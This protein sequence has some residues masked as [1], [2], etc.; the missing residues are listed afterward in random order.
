MKSFRQLYDKYVLIPKQFYESSSLK[1]RNTVKIIFIISII[2]GSLVLPIAFIENHFF[3][4]QIRPH[5]YTYYSFFLIVGVLGL[6]LRKTKI[7]TSALILLVLVLSQYVI[8]V[9]FVNAPFSSSVIIFIGFQFAFIMA[10][11]MN[12]V[13][14][15]A[16]LL[17]YTIFISVLEKNGIL[18]LNLPV[19][20]SFLINSSLFILV[21]FFLAFWKRKYQ[22]DEYIRDEKLS[23]ETKKSDELLHNILPDSVIEQLKTEGKVPPKNYENITVLVSDIV[24]F[25]K[26]ATDLP[27]YVLLIELN[28]IFT[29]FDRI[30]ETHNCIRIKTIGDAYMA[31]CGLP[32]KNNQHAENLMLCAKEFI[33][34]LE[35]RN[36]INPIKWSIRIG[37]A[38]G[39]A[40]AGIIGKKKYL[41]DILG[42]TVDYAIRLQNECTPMHIRLSEKTYE[43]LKDKEELNNTVEIGAK[44]NV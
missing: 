19:S 20:S 34:T 42:E 22:I 44:K 17:I 29:E 36:N 28:E 35:N 11:N 31:V 41:Y 9:N 8:T 23:E 26:T 37:L 38:S 14:F 43:L 33:K 5:A 32:E 13:M 1:N 6:L 27:P 10:L 16:D 30:C 2:F 18:K 39:S 12:P 25:T 7:P 40:I 4:I 21:I 15:T 24:D 3:N